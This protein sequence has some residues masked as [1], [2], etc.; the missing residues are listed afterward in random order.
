MSAISLDQTIKSIHTSLSLSLHYFTLETLQIVLTFIRSKMLS[1]TL[2]A[3]TSALL[4]AAPAAANIGQSTYRPDFTRS[5]VVISLDS[6][7]LAVWNT[8]FT[9]GT[10]QPEGVNLLQWSTKKQVQNSKNFRIQQVATE[11]QGTYQLA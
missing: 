10:G 6:N 11:T 4:L 5:N 8:T 9:K 7:P 2:F 3:L 1:S